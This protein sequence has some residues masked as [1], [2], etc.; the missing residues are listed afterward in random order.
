MRKKFL[1]HSGMVNSNQDVHEQNFRRV[2]ICTIKQ[3]FKHLENSDQELH[4]NAVTFCL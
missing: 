3:L 1:I 2:L 4:Y